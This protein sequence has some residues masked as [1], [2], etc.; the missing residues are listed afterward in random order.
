MSCREISCLWQPIVPLRWPKMPQ[1]TQSVFSL[2]PTVQNLS[3]TIQNCSWKHLSFSKEQCEISLN[4]EVVF[5]T[6]RGRSQKSNGN[7]FLAVTPCQ[8]VTYGVTQS[9]HIKWRSVVMPGDGERIS[10]S[11][12]KRKQ[13]QKRKYHWT[14]FYE[15]YALFTSHRNFRN[16]AFIWRETNGNTARDNK[17]QEQQQC[18]CSSRITAPEPDCEVQHFQMFLSFV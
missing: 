14:T 17:G 4:H 9:V 2:P 13:T 3:R 11:A 15:N 8:V 1:Y 10:Q 18:S 7:A 16:V 5:H 6:Y 12:L